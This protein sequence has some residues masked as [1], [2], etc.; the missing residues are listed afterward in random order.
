MA[1]TVLLL[2]ALAGCS[3][4]K[5]TIAGWAK[6]GGEKHVKAI[7]TDLKTLVE[8]SDQSTADPT[9]ASHCTQVLDDVKA[10]QAFR[11]PPDKSVNASWQEILNRVQTASSHCLRNIKTGGGSSLV[12]AIDAQTSFRDFL[13]EFERALSPS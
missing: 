8:A 11:D 12:E 6:N 7:A 4:Y 1:G 9:I 10:A 13:S 3:H 2:A 5:E